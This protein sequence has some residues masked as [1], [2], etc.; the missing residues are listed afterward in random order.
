MR[1]VVALFVGVVVSFAVRL[2]RADGCEVGKNDVGF[3]FLIP[4]RGCAYTIHSDV[5]FAGYTT[6][7]RD[8]FM[9]GAMEFGALEQIG[10]DGSPFHLGPMLEFAGS[11]WS[12][13]E[14]VDVL[15]T[16]EIVPRVRARLWVPPHDS[17]AWMLV[18]AAVGPAFALSETMAGGYVG[19][20]GFYGELGFS[21][22]GFAGGF[23]AF[24]YLTG[25][26][27][28]GIARE[29]RFMLGA[30]LTTGGFVLGAL[31]IAG[32]YACAEAGGC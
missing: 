13:H 31:I 29:P 4:W 32:I 7:G 8:W 1:W 24:E 5:T 9:R 6:N 28:A 23:V 17:D 22:H 26:P 16:W 10:G 27:L 2:A 3:G 11:G 15:P 20:A 19:R 18:E 12:A 21:V 14:E 30:K 25:D